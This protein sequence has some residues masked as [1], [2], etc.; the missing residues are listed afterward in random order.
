MSSMDANSN[1]IEK[2]H[3]FHDWNHK[4]G[5]SVMCRRVGNIL[6]STLDLLWTPT[7][8]RNGRHCWNISILS[9]LKD[10]Y[11]FFWWEK[12]VKS[13]GIYTP[14][15]L[16][17][18]NLFKN[19]SYGVWLKDFVSFLLKKLLIFD[20][21]KPI[22]RADDILNLTKNIVL[23]SNPRKRLNF[24]RVFKLNKENFKLLAD[25]SDNGSE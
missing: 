6:S 19:L 20:I 18:A 13:A 24:L 17:Q 15:L 5:F 9:L 21:L 8:K 25:I 11:C 12:R 1:F 14:V 4:N 16:R 23:N 2:Y 22:N 3:T 10:V 7:F